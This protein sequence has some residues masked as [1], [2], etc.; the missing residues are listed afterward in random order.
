MTRR[1]L[2]Y[3]SNLH[4][5]RLCDRLPSSR[6]LGVTRLQG[7]S[8]RFDKR[9]KDGSGKC[10]LSPANNPDDLAFG[11]VYEIA[12]REKELLDRIEGLGRGYDER[13]MDVIVNGNEYSV[14]TYTAQASYVNPELLPY[15]W[16]KALVLEGARFLEFPEDY[17]SYIKSLNTQADR[18]EARRQG[19]ERLLVRLQNYRCE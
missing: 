4:P 1:Y 15:D 10:H 13:S 5:L 12:A 11:A 6:L 8:V 18:N 17:V 2:A 3:G 16:Y 14:F 7:Y 19:N 9:S